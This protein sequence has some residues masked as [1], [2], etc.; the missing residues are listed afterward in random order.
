MGGTYN[1]M[2]SVYGTCDPTGVVGSTPAFAACMAAAI[3]AGAEM[4]IPVGI[5]NLNTAGLNI[6]GPFRLRGLGTALS[7]NTIAPFLPGVVLNCNG[8]GGSTSMFTFPNQGYLWGGLDVENISINYT[9]TGNVFN[10]CSFMDSIFRD[11]QI[12]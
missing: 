8:N 10:Q 1:L 12:S 4:I 11:L 2:N 5:Y 9:G 6:T 3:A 7:S